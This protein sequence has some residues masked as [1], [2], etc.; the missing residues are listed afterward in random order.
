[1]R[2]EHNVEKSRKDK[3]EKA[4]VRCQEVFLFLGEE[5]I[6]HHGKDEKL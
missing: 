5:D 3:R 1:M 2:E 4:Q 6:V